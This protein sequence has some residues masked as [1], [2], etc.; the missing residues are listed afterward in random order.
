MSNIPYFTIILD[1]ISR[2]NVEMERIFGRHVHWGY[3]E[4][5]ELAQKNSEDFAKAAERLSEK[6]IATAGIRNGMRILD[7]GCGFGG[8]IAHLNE[9]F[10]DLNLTGLNIE[11]RQ[12]ERARKIVLPRSDNTIQ[13]VQGDACKLPFADDSFD[14]VLAVECIFHFPD[15]LEFFKEAKRV[16]KKGGNLTLCDFISHKPRFWKIPSSFLIEKL[17]SVI[18]GKS[19]RCSLKDYH[20]IA[21]QSGLAV[22]HEEDIT[23]GTMPTYPVLYQ[24]GK[25]LKKFS[26]WSSITTH[27]I[28]WGHRL[29]EVKYMVLSFRK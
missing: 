25:T 9:N 3:W 13:F 14:V 12:L 11:E 17:I 8:T 15:R 26:I 19:K 28:E 22:L 1:E 18:Y 29:G 4:K 7:V 2:G 5:P 6:L 24:L 27:F 20:Q 21:D 10:S 23:K 16:L